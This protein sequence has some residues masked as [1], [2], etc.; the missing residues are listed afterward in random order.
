[1][2]ARAAGEEE[3]CTFHVGSLE[4]ARTSDMEEVLRG[5]FGRSGDTPFHLTELTAPGFPRVMI[6]PA[7]LKEIRRLLYSRLSQTLLPRIQEARRRA[8]EMALI[9]PVLSADLK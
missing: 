2:T 5:Q 7:R 9:N 3:T 6:P 8:K 4:E 1:M